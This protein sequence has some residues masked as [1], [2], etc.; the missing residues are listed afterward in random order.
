ML[1][2][3]CRLWCHQRLATFGNCDVEL[4]AT[5]AMELAPTRVLAKK[6]RYLIHLS[7]S[8]LL[9]GL[10]WSHRLMTKGSLCNEMS[11]PSINWARWCLSVTQSPI[12]G[13]GK[14]NEGHIHHSPLNTMRKDCFMLW[15]HFF[16]V[17]FF[18]KLQSFH[19]DSSYL[20]CA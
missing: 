10:S 3:V 5:E 9:F 4:K 6:V 8:V 7:L 12:S 20:T 19:F 17:A 13:R 2:C 15:A 18:V 16:L 14:G 1:F 11:I